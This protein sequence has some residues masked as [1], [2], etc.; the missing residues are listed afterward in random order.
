MSLDYNR[1]AMLL[2]VFDKVKEHPKLGF[3][4]QQV[5]KD[6]Q[7]IN[8][9]AIAETKPK[10]NPVMARPINPDGQ[11]DTTNDPNVPIESIRRNP[12]GTVVKVDPLDTPVERRV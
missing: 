1:I 3:I 7:D 6:L 10:P 5:L 2:H 12:D 4:C 11:T 8:D 9:E